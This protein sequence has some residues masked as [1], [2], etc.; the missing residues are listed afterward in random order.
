M[1]NQVKVQII[2]WNVTLDDGAD[3]IA[4]SHYAPGQKP[5]HKGIDAN[6]DQST[7]FIPCDE[8]RL[9]QKASCIGEL[10]KRAQNSQ[11]G[12]AATA[13]RQPGE[14]AL[15]AKGLALKV[16][17]HELGPQP[18]GRLLTRQADRPATALFYTIGQ[19]H[20]PGCWWRPAILCR[21]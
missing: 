2:S 5:T 7:F 3:L 19:R 11:S 13:K 6:K 16:L 17:L 4:T 20:G 15:S 8:G 14:F 10:E 21:P 1:C 18:N 12:E 9:A